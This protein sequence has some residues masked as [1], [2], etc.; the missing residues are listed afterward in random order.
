MK[1]DLAIK[2]GGNLKAIDSTNRVGGYLV[3]FTEQGRY[4][5]YG[6]RFCEDTD[7]NMTAYPVKGSP[8]LYNH[9][10][11]E[12]IGSVPIGVFDF[13][14]VDDVGI[15][16]EAQLY[17]KE[18]YEEYLRL[19]ATERKV[20]MTDEQIK[21]QASL[22][23]HAVK[24]IMSKEGMAYSSGALPQSVLVDETLD[25]ETGA[26]LDRKIKQ[27]YIIEGSATLTPAEPQLTKVIVS[28]KALAPRLASKDS[29][30]VDVLINSIGDNPNMKN[31]ALDAVMREEI[32]A[33]VREIITQMESDEA[34]AESQLAVDALAEEA[35]MMMEE[36]KAGDPETAEQ[37]MD[38]MTE[39]E[40]KAFVIKFVRDA[41][42]ISRLVKRAMTEINTYRSQ[43]ANAVKQAIASNTPVKSQARA[44]VGSV[45]P[46]VSD[47]KDLRYAH[48]TAEDMQVAYLMRKASTK[49]MPF[50]DEQLFSEDFIKNLTHKTSEHIAKDPYARP[51]ANIAAKGA[52]PFRANEL[53]ASTL[54]GQGLEWVGVQYGNAVWERK[55][56]PR[57]YDRLVEK[58]AMIFDVTGAGSAVIPV[59]G[60][61]PIAYASPEAL[62]VDA[63]GR[64]EVTANVSPFQTANVTVTPREIKIA[65]S[66][67][68]VLDESAIVNLA[69]QVN[70]QLG[71]KLAETRDQLF[72][73]GDTA[74][75]ANTNVNLID[76]TPAGG[77][78]RPYYL[79]SDGLR[80]V[81]RVTATAQS[82]AIGAAIARAN[83][84]GT[85]NLLPLAL[86]SRFDELLFLCDN[87]TYQGLKAVP[88]YV[89]P[90][91]NANN[92]LA[93][94]EGGRLV[95]V[96]G[97]DL[98]PTEFMPLTNTAGMVSATAGNN[99]R[100]SL[101]LVFAPYV[102][103]AYS[104]NV[105]ME[106]AR[107]ILSGTDLYVLSV[108]MAFQN[109]STNAY[110]LSYNI[111]V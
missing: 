85:L 101:G 89:D 108:R 36:T 111:V 4:D 106:T 92:R 82:L 68:T 83:V 76:G 86:Q 64:P 37:K 55:R 90:F 98:F 50:S 23:W 102:A 78:F 21:E 67:T 91:A 18:A 100:G 69:R 6:D 12:K 110:A 42:T 49:G 32:T 84:L 10:M 39:E 27:W 45:S 47:M 109:R 29:D 3:A 46:R 19:R 104:R 43:R 38:G 103:V 77:L 35:Q 63:T 33:L 57:F 54:T 96:D 95:G 105:T 11:D 75:A 65:S 22:A 30:S 81:T 5:L 97:V 2:Y 62:S 99:T 40:Q 70:Y 60:N 51:E 107:D 9:G 58:G 1:N 88:E 14:N 59:E 53:D 52:F 61:D 74:T 15:W 94:F 8:L 73:N 13:V 80:K 79:V 34:E 7:F 41:K 56:Q 26:P 93:V 17:D 66:Y 24:T 31:K 20:N 28:A 44:N 71:E 72:L 48:L 25:P 87:G 16:A